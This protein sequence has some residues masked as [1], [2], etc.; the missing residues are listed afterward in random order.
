MLSVV[1]LNPKSNRGFQNSFFPNYSANTTVAHILGEWCL[2]I[3]KGGIDIQV[4][5]CVCLCM[6]YIGGYLVHMFVVKRLWPHYDIISLWLTTFLL[7][8][9]FQHLCFSSFLTLYIYI[10]SSY[11]C[12]FPN[13]CLFP[14]SFLS[15]L[16]CLCVNLFILLPQVLSLC[17]WKTLLLLLLLFQSLLFPLLP[18]PPP[19]CFLP[20]PP[21]VGHLRGHVLE[22]QRPIGMLGSPL[23]LT[24]HWTLSRRLCGGEV[25]SQSVL[26]PVAKVRLSLVHLHKYVI[27]NEIAVDTKSCYL[28]ILDD[29]MSPSTGC[30]V[31][32]Q[33]HD[34]FLN[35]YI[36]PSL[37][38]CR[39]SVSSDSVYWPPY[40]WGGPREKV[41]L[42]SQ[43][44]SWGGTL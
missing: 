32:L 19:L 23:A 24:C 43:T 9:I 29:V 36:C 22:A 5:L 10:F 15:C 11:S 16:I 30:R 33:E 8:S 18:P 26:L 27:L 42:C 34:V 21:T 13:L 6:T 31:Q 7:F 28:Y 40:R 25:D 38:V 17:Q 4:C 35:L 41:W 20:P 37:S 12:L 44:C 39:F 1:V 2:W 3:R 14:L